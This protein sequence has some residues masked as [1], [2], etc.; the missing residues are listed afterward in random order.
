MPFYVLKIF[1]IKAPSANGIPTAIPFS[2]PFP[3]NIPI[4][5]NGE[6]HI[7]CHNPLVCP[8]S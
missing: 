7:P 1:V 4:V 2:I 6:F 5:A 3:T 8:I